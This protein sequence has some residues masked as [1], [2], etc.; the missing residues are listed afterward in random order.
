LDVR[1]VFGENTNGER[2]KLAS[3]RPLLENILSFSLTNHQIFEI[4]YIQWRKKS[5]HYR[6][7]QGSRA[8]AT[9]DGRGYAGFPR[10]LFRRIEVTLGIQDLKI[11]DK[12]FDEDTQQWGI[13][14]NIRPTMVWVL[15][16]ATGKVMATPW[17]LAEEAL[18]AGDW[19]VSPHQEIH[20]IDPRK[21]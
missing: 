19:N 13:V 3:R 11:N 1:R 17:F 15:W 7:P 6:R 12:I 21:G 2:R 14:T 8:T 10:F 5:S 16:S 4:M 20:L 18:R 9:T